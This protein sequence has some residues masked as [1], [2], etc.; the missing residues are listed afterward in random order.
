MI[1]NTFK[2]TSG[3]YDEQS[4]VDSAEF[5]VIVSLTDHQDVSLTLTV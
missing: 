4:A 2:V 5:T 3:T 1:G